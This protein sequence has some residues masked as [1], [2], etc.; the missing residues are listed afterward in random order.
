MPCALCQTRKPRRFCP[1]LHDRICAV[2]CGTAREVTLDCPAD[3]PWLQQARAHEKPRPLEELAASGVELFPR[4]EISQGFLHERQPLILGLS[5]ALARTVRGFPELNDR[6]LIAALTTL[7]R[8]YERLAS[9]GLHYQEPAAGGA[10]Q[11]LGEELEK[12][13]AEY[14]QVEIRHLGYA[15][16]RDADVLKA[17]VFLLRLGHSRTSGRPRSRACLDFLR[18]QFPE[19]EKTIASPSDAP[20][21]IIVP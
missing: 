6:D 8:S 10:Q 18:V 13:I 11:V 16:L 19:K 1:A 21:R 15:S 9:S 14:R 3:C 5:F 17:L 12:M 4:L 20:G 7:A 2:C